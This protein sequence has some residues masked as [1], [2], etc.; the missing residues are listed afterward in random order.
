MEHRPKC[1]S[2]MHEGY[3]DTDR[4]STETYQNLE[5]QKVEVTIEDKP[6]QLYSQAMRSCPQWDEIS[7]YFALTSK[8]DK[9]T[10]KIAND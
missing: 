4:K 10:V 7:K 1:S 2:K 8:R 6:N 3:F 5:I 9:G